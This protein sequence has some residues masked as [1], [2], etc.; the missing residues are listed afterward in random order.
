MDP[1]SQSKDI[2]AGGRIKRITP[3]EE[4]KQ[5]LKDA[6]PE[7]VTTIYSEAGLWYDA[8]GSISNLC[9]TSPKG[10]QYCLGRRELL[11]QVDLSLDLMEIAKAEEEIMVPKGFL[12]PPSLVP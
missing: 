12:P 6:M 4:L 10:N 2:V 3:D 9:E 5:K 1:K 8:L 11:E 7:H